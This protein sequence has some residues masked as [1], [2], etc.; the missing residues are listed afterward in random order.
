MENPRRSTGKRKPEHPGPILRTVNFTARC[1]GSV[2]LGNAFGRYRFTAEGGRTV[3][4][5][6]KMVAARR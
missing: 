1:N 6:L 2:Q 5:P 4:A 3:G